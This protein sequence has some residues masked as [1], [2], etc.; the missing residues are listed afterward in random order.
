MSSTLDSL[1]LLGLFKSTPLASPAPINPPP[2]P[3]SSSPKSPTLDPLVLEPPKAENQRF[4]DFLDEEEFSF[5]PDNPHSRTP[6]LMP[7]FDIEEVTFKLPTSPKVPRTS[8]TPQPST[9]RKNKL[10]TA[11]AEVI[12]KNLYEKGRK[13]LVEK[14]EKRERFFEEAYSFKPQLDPKS[15]LMVK[16]AE[17]EGRSLATPKKKEKPSPQP[18]P[19]ENKQTKPQVNFKDFIKRNYEIALEQTKEKKNRVATPPDNRITEDCTFKPRIDDKS[20][21]MPM[22]HKKNLYE[23]A[24]QLKKDREKQIEEW[25]AKKEEEELKQCTFSPAIIKKTNLS[26]TPKD[27]QPVQKSKTLNSYSAQ[28]K[29][30]QGKSSKIKIKS[31]FKY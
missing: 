15:L 16:Y 13:L 8:K 1:K 30:K 5:S 23:L 25:K 9:K 29:A 6:D 18:N 12:F 2:P 4:L 28:M 20:K 19:E 11:D 17:K 14:Q 21:Q 26:P 10:S 27:K 31:Q 7:D 3:T 24:D 22:H